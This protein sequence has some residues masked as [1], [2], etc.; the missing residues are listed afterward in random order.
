MRQQLLLA[1]K[2]QTK[3]VWTT[4]WTRSRYDFDLKT[5]RQVS[6]TEFPPGNFATDLTPVVTESSDPTRNYE[7]NY[8]TSLSEYAVVATAVNTYSWRYVLIFPGP[9]RKGPGNQEICRWTVRQAVGCMSHWLVY[10]NSVVLVPW[11]ILIFN[12]LRISCWYT[13]R[14]CETHMYVYYPQHTSRVLLWRLTFGVIKYWICC[15][16]DEYYVKQK[17]LRLRTRFDKWL[18]K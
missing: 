13:Y 3:W 2:A 8:K 16:I 15:Q 11:F 6:V 5:D 17:S 1:A 4:M 14:T 9:R 12:R 18:I 7:R 10:A